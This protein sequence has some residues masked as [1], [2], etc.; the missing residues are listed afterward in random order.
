MNIKSIWAQNKLKP[1]L[2]GGV[3]SISVSPLQGAESLSYLV[4]PG[5]TACEIAE[6]FLVPCAQLIQH[7]GLGAGHQIFVGQTLRLPGKVPPEAP[8]TAPQVEK[9]N[10][11]AEATAA[12]TETPSPT[13]PPATKIDL[14]TVYQ[15]AVADDPVFVAAGFR[16]AAA[17]QAVPITQLAVRPQLS[18][19][20]GYTLSTAA[21]A[22]DNFSL[23][24][25]L[26]QNLYDRSTHIAVDQARNE[27]SIAN[28]EHLIEK[29]RL[30][31]RVCNAYFSVLAARDDVELSTSNQRAIRRQLELAEE[32]LAVGV[33]TRTDLYDAR[34]RF[35]NA[36]ASGI[37]S[38]K[39][40]RDARQALVALVDEDLSDLQPLRTDIP[41][42]APEPNAV[43]H[44]VEA[45]LT[46]NLALRQSALRV[47]VAEQDI[48][49]QQA[50]R[51]P[52]L[53]LNLNG[54]LD[55]SSAASD[56]TSLSVGLSVPLYEGDLVGARVRQA[57]LR[58][59]A[60]RADLEA[61]QREVRRLTRN[62]FFTVNSHLR[63]VSALAESVRAGENALKAKEEGFAAG[64]T[65]NIDVLDAQR[66][67]F[68]A[69][70]NYLKARYD[71]ILQV[72]ALEQL[73]GRLDQADLDRFNQWLE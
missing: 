63:R 62:A 70:R 59:N 50:A 36:I 11:T 37:E 18:V 41:L 14:V 15:N 67:V 64:L 1:A 43:E 19:R 39:T 12:P 68:A 6:L 54:G 13:P 55:Y 21:A 34:A 47:Y 69:K 44:W 7:N 71:Y 29:Q 10:N 66:D 17:Q 23:S 16:R 48:S 73:A 49:R 52:V 5:D 45:A 58:H 26:K 65:T 9:P 27:A 33:G 53:S 20:S 60:V 72:L 42:A 51:F 46:D 22:D 30:L 2:L 4:Q 32:R 31:L 38:E 24:V 57:A 40:V 28:L 35:E 61:H 56:R 8:E 3:L 25:S